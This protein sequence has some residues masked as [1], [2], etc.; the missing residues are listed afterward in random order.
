MVK[1]AKRYK[2]SVQ[3][4]NG[5]NEPGHSR[6]T[7]VDDS[8]A[9]LSEA[10]VFQ[11]MARPVR[12][13]E[14][15]SLLGNALMLNGVATEVC[16]SSRPASGSEHLISHALDAISARPRLHGLQGGVA[17]FVGMPVAADASA[18]CYQH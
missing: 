7:L 8:A 13:L 3:V 15:E 11:F 10:T 16:G 5:T 14:G 2:S 6:G 9:L 17:S 18:G 4:A 1:V 12:D